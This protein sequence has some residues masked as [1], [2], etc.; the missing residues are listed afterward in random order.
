MSDIFKK[1]FCE[2]H[3]QME[4]LLDSKESKYSGFLEKNQIEIEGNSLLEWK[5]KAR[6]LLNKACG[7]NSEHYKEFLKNEET[8]LYGT[9][10]ATL[11][12]LKAIFLAARED[13]EGGYLR[14][15][16]SLIQAEVFDSELEQAMALHEAGYI[17]P[18]AIV[19][20]VVLETSLRELCDR[21]GIPHGK[22]DKMNSD[23]AKAGIY[24][25]LQQKRITA[26]A[27]IRN[28]AAHGKSSEFSDQDVVDMVRDVERF[29][30]GH[31]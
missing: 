6:S 11:E 19:A 20:G 2:L 16:R 7:E 13:Y 5:V 3:Q 22:L 15:T 8:G 9:H 4:D 31:L 30:A 14:E 24:N 29:I 12:R 25:K 21:E 17:S 18:A 26:L 1:R 27:D 23:L 10:L 28:S